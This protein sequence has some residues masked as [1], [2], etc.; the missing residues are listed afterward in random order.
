[1]ELNMLKTK[2]AK[3]PQPKQNRKEEAKSKEI[4]EQAMKIHR[5]SK[6]VKTTRSTS[7]ARS[8]KYTNENQIKP[9]S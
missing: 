3:D 7:P 2:V 5:K 4:A 6:K 9:M 1:M 8:I